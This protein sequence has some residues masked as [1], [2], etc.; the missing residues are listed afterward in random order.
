MGSLVPFALDLSIGDS[1]IDITAL[2]GVAATFRK[3]LNPV[4]QGPS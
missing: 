1:G 4:R 2:R 3:P